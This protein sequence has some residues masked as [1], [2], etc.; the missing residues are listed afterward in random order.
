MI[1]LNCSDKSTTERTVQQCNTT[2]GE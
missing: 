1:L 2:K